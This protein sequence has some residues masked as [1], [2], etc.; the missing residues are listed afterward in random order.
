MGQRQRGK[1]FLESGLWV[2]LEVAAPLSQSLQ[3]LR[4]RLDSQ[5]P[6]GPTVA[7]LIHLKVLKLERLLLAGSR[8]YQLVPADQWQ[9]AVRDV[10]ALTAWL[11]TAR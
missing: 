2:P 4:G 5:R 9:R 3:L 10:Q 6:V 8:H 11:A 7:L 1:I